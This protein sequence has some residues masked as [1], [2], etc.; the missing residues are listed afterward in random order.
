MH[1]LPNGTQ[2]YSQGNEEVVILDWFKRKGMPVGRF[3]DIGAYNPTVFSNTRRLFEGGWSG[4][5]V[6]PGPYQIVKLAEAYR[7]V[8]RVTIVNCALA[9]ANKFQEFGICP[10]ALSS[11]DKEHQKTWEAGGTK[12][13]QV[14]VFTVSIASFF[15]KFGPRFD[16]V[17]IDIEGEANWN[18]IRTINFGAIRASLLCLEYG[19]R[20]AEIIEYVRPW[21]YSVIHDTGENLLMGWHA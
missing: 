19:K 1:T 13:D 9:E 10:D 5:F 8:D 11:L 16:F 2:V 6:E 20:R 17:D 12:Y 4:V 15:E 3:L 21:G 18:L 14:Q 7:G